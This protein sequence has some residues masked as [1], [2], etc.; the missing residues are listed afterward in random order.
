MKEIIRTFRSPSFSKEQD[1]DDPEKSDSKNGLVLFNQDFATD[2][3]ALT[4][5]KEGIMATRATRASDVLK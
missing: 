1:A 3:A 5:P 2:S 4:S